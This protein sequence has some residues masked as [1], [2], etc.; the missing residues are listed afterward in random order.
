M[1]G[2][3][4]WRESSGFTEESVWEF[5]LNLSEPVPNKHVDCVFE[6]SSSEIHGVGICAKRDVEK[7]ESFPVCTKYERYKTARY[8]NHSDTPNAVVEF[9]DCG[10]GCIR[11]QKHIKSGEEVLT[12]YN[13]NMRK[14]LEASK[15]FYGTN[16][17]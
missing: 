4:N 10:N 7:G 12:D 9:D 8:I 5:M 16:Q 11:I 13:D 3:E 14:S 1:M 2:Y 15:A 17:R 6:V